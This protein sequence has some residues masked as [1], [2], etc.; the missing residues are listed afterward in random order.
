MYTN[1]SVLAHMDSK[2]GGKPQITMNQALSHFISSTL[3]KS[4]QIAKVGVWGLN[5]STW[6]CWVAGDLLSHIEPSH[7]FSSTERT[8]SMF[9]RQ[10]KHCGECA[11]L[12]YYWLRM[13]LNVLK[14]PWSRK[15][16]SSNLATLT[17]LFPTFCS[18]FFSSSCFYF[19]VT[20]EQSAKNVAH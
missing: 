7:S 11:T 16:C 4:S 12:N 5:W 10:S 15:N 2:L 6:L 3:S 9:S 19:Y 17:F 8:V 20:E 1:A 14:T 18:T 13:I